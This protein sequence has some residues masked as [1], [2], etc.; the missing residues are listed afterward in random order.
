MLF[1]EGKRASLRLVGAAALLVS[2]LWTFRK[3]RVAE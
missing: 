1:A 2:F 3:D